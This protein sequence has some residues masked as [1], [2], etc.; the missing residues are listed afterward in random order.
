MIEVTVGRIEQVKDKIG[1]MLKFASPGHGENNL[2]KM[3]GQFCNF[4]DV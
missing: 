2:E 1:Q 4:F 3:S